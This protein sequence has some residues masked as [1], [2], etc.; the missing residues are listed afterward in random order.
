M[1][2]KYFDLKLISNLIKTKDFL[3]SKVKTT[4]CNRKKIYIYFYIITL[5]VLNLL[6]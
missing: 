4:F 3:R 1:T 2:Y 6:S 5:K